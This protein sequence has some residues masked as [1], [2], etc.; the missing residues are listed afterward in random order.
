MKKILFYM[1]ALLIM[2]AACSPDKYSLGGQDYKASDLVQGEAYTVTPDANNPNIIYLKSLL[3]DNY[4]PCWVTPYGTSQSKE[5]TLNIAFPG[6]Y[7]VTYGVE[8][9][10]GIVYGEPYTFSIASFCSD[11]V[12]DP[13]WTMLAGGVGNSKKWFVDLDAD[14]VSRN[15][16]GPVYF[17]GLDDCWE[18]ITEGKDSPYG[19]DVWAWDADWSGVSGWQ[20]S[21][22]AQD[23]GYM[24]F[25]LKGGPNVHVVMNEIGKDLTGTYMLD[26]DN[27]TISFANGAELLHESVNDGAVQSWSGEL[28]LLSLT[29]D[30]MQVAVIRKSDPCILCI[31]FIS[32]DYY[33]N[34]D[35][36]AG[37]SSD[38][39]PELGDDWR[40]DVSEFFKDGNTYRN[41]R[42][43]FTDESNAVDICA[44]D[45]TAEGSG[46]QAAS[47]EGSEYK[48][49]LNFYEGTYTATN[50]E[51]D[52]VT[53]ALSLEDG[54]FM[55]FSNGLP[56]SS[57]G[58]NGAYF[59]TNE[60]NTL[61]ILS[62][63]IDGGEMTDIWL[64]VDINDIH[65]TRYKYQGYHFV[66]A[67]IGGV[68]VESFKADMHYFNTG[69]TFFDSDNVKIT[70]E[71]TYT[72]TITGADS[73]PYGIYLDVKK[74]LGKYP[75]MDM[76]IT[77]MRV[78]G[79][80]IA[81][82]DALIDRGVGDDATTARRYIL[83]PWNSDNY[84]M[85]NGYDVLK[86]AS[87]IEVDIKIIYDNGTPFISE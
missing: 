1:A 51:G 22:V 75:N 45:G 65:G 70:G 19:T 12:S 26:T 35:P 74:I 5:V 42:L 77:D 31:N 59:T 82:D 21:S 40:T 67:I 24:E 78:D 36:N 69:W 28:R 62:Y 76:V 38:V 61:R 6:E 60:D 52:E 63:T 58:A 87:S 14:G 49:D 30:A 13:M 80:S 55:K 3:P 34:W 17:K 47:D 8:T 54:G 39:A 18:T 32:E 20:W 57:V 72:F 66:P 29:D 43:K 68:E 85:A 73:D 4:L 86:F 48:L 64:G 10:G 41:F 9:R 56:E 33:N 16:Y 7:E 84:F 50:A 11:F 25:D 44:L 53:G 15:F 79:Q 46:A 27:H 23:F 81:F 37:K 71:G 83:N 2:F